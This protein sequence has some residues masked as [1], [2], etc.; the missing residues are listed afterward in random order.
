MFDT[1]HGAM[2]KAGT[3]ASVLPFLVATL[4]FAH[5]GPVT[6]TIDAA[7]KKQPGVVF[8]H[9]KHAKLV[10]TC[11]T[12]H[13]TQKSLKSDKD[14]KVVKCSTCHLDPKGKALSMREMSLT[15]NPFHV[16]CMACHKEQKKGPIA[17]TGCH[18]KK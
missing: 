8:Q 6:V 3:M 13:H 11:D 1:R 18:V 14:T 7:A 5:H 16:R 15:K 4:A 17:C 12:C 10:K 2:S 9:E